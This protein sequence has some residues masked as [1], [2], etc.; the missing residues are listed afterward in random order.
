V[1]VAFVGLRVGMGA[2]PSAAGRNPCAPPPRPPGLLAATV[3]RVVDGD[4]A[5][6]RLPDGRNERVRLI[7]IDTPE[8][9]ASEKLA[10]ESAR[11]GRDA[12]TLRRLGQRAAAFTSAWL[13]VGLRIGL[14]L[15]IEPCDREGR[16]LAY[17]WRDDGTFINLALVEAGQARL[18]TIPPNV[19]HADRF[20]A[21]AA[22]AR[23][24]RRGL[25]A[26]V[27][28]GPR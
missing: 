24:A 27:D 12:D 22:A 21:C 2:L 15:D 20:R 17:V 1:L 11:T 10:R 5:V 16:L 9:H 13:P 3:R 25:W 6:V 14:E 19:R 7:G 26:S 28:Q 23:T 4:T 18:L 8:I